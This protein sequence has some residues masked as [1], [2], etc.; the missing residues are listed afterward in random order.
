M[1]M[2]KIAILFFSLALP[3]MISGC[4]LPGGP[5]ETAKQVE[6]EVWGVFDS[7]DAYE[8]IIAAYELLRP[9]I[10]VNYKK[11]RWEEYQD[12]LLQA[13]AEDRGPDV[14]LVHNTWVKNYESKILPMPKK[15]KVPTLVVT[16]SSFN[17]KKETKIIESNTPSIEQIKNGFVDVVWRDANLENNIYGLPLSVDN[18]ALFYNRSLLDAAGVVEPPTTWQELT[19]VA[20]KI[21]RQDAEGNIIRSAIAL[22][23]ADNIFRSADILSLLMM[24]NGTQMT[25]GGE[26][27]FD[28]VSSYDPG[29]YPGERALEFYTDFS[30]PLKEVY[31]WN[32]DLP[33][34][35]DAFLQGKVAMIFG[36]S[37]SLPYIESQGQRLNF[38]VAPMLHINK[39]GSDGQVGKS[40]NFASYWL[41]SAAK[42]TA[43]P[44]EAWDFILF[45]TTNSYEDA[46]GERIYQA[47]SYLEKTSRPPALRS[48]INKFRQRQDLEPFVSQSLTAESWYRGT[49]PFSAEEIFKQMIADVV[50]GRKTAREAIRFGVRAVQSTY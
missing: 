7:S 22:G 23:G 30:L 47:E 33:E 40:I 4:L 38:A 9:N 3:L 49:D 14:F 5:S 28:E 16:G 39:D 18:L 34:A 36:F 1:N 11:L 46:Q 24:Q 25:K 48:L 19:E 27:S 20:K 2:K 29:Y 32:S 43:Y 10:K 37:Y 44:N 12:E 6:L 21:T 26:V 31:T 15:L 42:K 13:W 17:K 8:E 41:L 50:S 45:A 35:T